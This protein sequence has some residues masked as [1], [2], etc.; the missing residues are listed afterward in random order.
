MPSR[1]SQAATKCDLETHCVSRDTVSSTRIAAS[2]PE[3]CAT[4]SLNV[5]ALHC[6]W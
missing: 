4:V 2:K 6:T 3:Q 5:E 1:S